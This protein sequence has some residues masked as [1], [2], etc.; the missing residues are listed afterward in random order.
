MFL[1]ETRSSEDMRVTVYRREC[2]KLSTKKNIYLALGKILER[3]GPS[4]SKRDTIHLGNIK[5]QEWLAKSVAA[6]NGCSLV[7]LLSWT[8][9][10]RPEPT[11]TA[12]L[13]IS[14]IHV[15]KLTGS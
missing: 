7:G 11:P 9:K 5:H 15:M 12:G 4:P 14:S 3:G 8:V 2:G 10:V 13:H 1:T 6:L